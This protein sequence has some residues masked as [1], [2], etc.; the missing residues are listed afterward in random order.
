M[1]KNFVGMLAKGEI[2]L[3]LGVFLLT[4]PQIFSTFGLP[5]LTGIFAQIATLGGLILVGWAGINVIMRL[6]K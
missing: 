3:A 5:A 6:F 1:A 4:L 2:A